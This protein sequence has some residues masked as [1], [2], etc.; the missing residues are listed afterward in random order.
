MANEKE[1]SQLF[2]AFVFPRVFQAFRQAIQPSKLIIALL[3]VAVLCGV[4]QIMDLSKPVAATANNQGQ[5]TQ[6]ELQVYMTNPA[7]VP[8]FIEAN[9]PTGMRVGIFSTLWHF[10]TSRF[11]G[12]IFR[13]FVLDI[14]GVARNIAE[15]F[16]AFAWAFRYHT[17]YTIVFFIIALAV[18]SVTGGAICRAAALQCA[19]GEKPGLTEAL[20]FS[21]KR[22]VSFFATPLTPIGIIVF[23]GLFIFVL[24]LIGNIPWVGELLMGICMPLTLIA[25]GLIAAVAIGAVVGLDLMFPAIAYDNSDCFDSISRSF[26]YVYARPWHIIFYTVVAA[27]YGAICYVFVRS[28]SFVLLWGSYRIL[29]LGVLG[30]NSKLN[31][32]WPE[33][34]F[35]NF[36]GHSASAAGNWSETIAAFLVY[37]FVLAIIGLLISFVLSF[38]FS[39]NTIIYALM[40]SKVDNTAI[41][42]VYTYSEE[43]EATPS[44]AEGESDET[45]PSSEGDTQTESTSEESRTPEEPPPSEQ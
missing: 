14:P 40:R 3:A 8:S 26:S 20:S 42:D 15:F 43:P 12:A 2:D 25:G 13:L 1:P 11:H 5:V 45:K 34:H 35:A 18:I 16:K 32:I 41:D 37:I 4:G 27:I 44:V 10:G 28:F 38:Y 22:F 17:I 21:T 19:R 24:G 39:A 30:N 6:T 31:A 23:I 36:L 33:P 7:Q 29:R 9:R